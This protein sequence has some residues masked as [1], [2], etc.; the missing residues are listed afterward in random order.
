MNIYEFGAHEQM[1]RR[2][3]RERK[4]NS[5]C[6]QSTKPL[7]SLDGDE[8]EAVEAA[9]IRKT[10][11]YSATETTSA[12]NFPSNEE[13]FRASTD[14]CKGVVQPWVSDLEDEYRSH[15][16]E[17]S[18]LCFDIPKLSDPF[19]TNESKQEV[20]ILTGSLPSRGSSAELVKKGSW[21]KE[22]DEL[23]KKFGG[24]ATT[25]NWTEIAE[26]IPGRTAK[27]CRERWCFNLDPSINK[28]PWSPEEDLLLI[29]KQEEFGN[30]WAQIAQ[31]LPGRTENAVKTRFKSI[32]RA[33]KR[34]WNPSEDMRLLELYQVVG[35]NWEKIASELSGRRTKHAVKMRFK[36]LQAGLDLVKKPEYGSAR[37]TVR[38]KYYPSKTLKA[39]SNQYK[40]MICGE[41]SSANVAELT[42]FVVQ[43]PQ[44]YQEP[45]IK[46]E[47]QFFQ[48]TCKQE[49]MFN[50]PVSVFSLQ[51]P[52]EDFF[53]LC[54]E[55]E[56][57]ALA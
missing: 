23:L 50:N 17:F 9:G 5:V 12:F 26:K 27:Q 16:L 2:P 40:L 24:I 39:V 51:D 55:D 45:K 29:S 41:I 33:Q 1:G 37:Q 48:P 11:R 28:E 7:Y 20:P 44:M 57:F 53:S 34:E 3:L 8:L 56:K 35:G 30:K 6:L 32:D 14:F 54:V 21:T 13:D 4:R 31:L 47:K 38:E 18:Q 19:L 46:E 42:K 15:N 43:R 25:K 10:R 22:E 36:D 52:F 49:P